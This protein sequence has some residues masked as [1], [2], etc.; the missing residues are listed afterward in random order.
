MS[1]SKK[2][3]LK[4]TISSL[5][6]YDLLLIRTS[7]GINPLISGTSKMAFVDDKNPHPNVNW[8]VDDWFRVAGV[9]SDVEFAD[10][11]A[12]IGA[13]NKDL[14][15]NA[16]RINEIRNRLTGINKREQALQWITVLK[17]IAENNGIALFTPERIENDIAIFL[18]SKACKE[19]YA[20]ASNSELRDI[21]KYSNP[22]D[23]DE[24]ETP[25]YALRSRVQPPPPR[26]LIGRDMD[27]MR[28]LESL[29]NNSITAID[30]V[31]G[32]GKTSLAWVCAVHGCQSRL[33]TNF[34]WITDKRHILNLSGEL[35]PTFIPEDDISFFE[36]MLISL[37][38]QFGWQDLLG[39]R[40][41]NLINKCADRLRAGRYLLVVDN[42][43]SVADSENIIYQLTDM[44]I[45]LSP[46]EPISSRALITTREQIS[47]PNVNRISIV[48]IEKLARHQL[49]NY[50]QDLWRIQ[51]RLSPSQ[52]TKLAELTG[53]NPLFIQFALQSYQLLR[54]SQKFDALFEALTQHQN[55]IFAIL[56]ESVITKL[57][58]AS[59]KFSKTIAL[60]L[61]I[62]REETTDEDLR[63]I[64]SSIEGIDHEGKQF[65]VA[66][67]ELIT[68]RIINWSGNHNRNYTMHPLIQ[69]YFL[70]S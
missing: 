34:D 44:L 22:D 13:S 69:S 23:N 64:W 35:I 67:S 59:V 49:I 20:P 53:G 19:Q 65:M 8:T 48:G 17:T 66:L 37:C 1:F 63:Y 27:F 46:I 3:N 5:A 15:W 26:N 58:P 50:L 18:R 10:V 6:K 38:R 43:E 56:I 61:A 12:Y 4:S 51:P 21:F 39:A 60:E 42:I 47:H 33:Y 52:V 30:G 70:G 41:D 2:R 45:P 29:R 11:A 31:A 25:I 62:S 36:N 55:E 54:T 57:S 24:Q 40:D 68:H 7:R 32:D 16:K 9:T 14:P 28:V